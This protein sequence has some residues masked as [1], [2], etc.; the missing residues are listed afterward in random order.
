MAPGLGG[1]T[2]FVVSVLAAVVVICI[3]L[4]KKRFVLLE[5][6]EKARIVE[7]KRQKSPQDCH[8]LRSNQ[9]QWG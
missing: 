7:F 4:T 1:L 8:F 9:P 2:A 6:P 5:R 3:F